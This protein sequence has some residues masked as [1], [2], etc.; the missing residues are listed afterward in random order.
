M[1]SISTNP[2]NETSPPPPTAA[3]IFSTEV[4]NVQRAGNSG[5]IK[6]Q[7]STQ[8]NDSIQRAKVFNYFNSLLHGKWQ[9]II[10]PQK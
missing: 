5:L 7:K 3:T 2:C 4:S 1:K 10:G 9:K 6:E 8:E